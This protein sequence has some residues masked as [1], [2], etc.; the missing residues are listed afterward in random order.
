MFTNNSIKKCALPKPSV[1]LHGVD[2]YQLELEVPAK[3]WT[4]AT[5]TKLVRREYT[6]HRSIRL[7]SNDET[8]SFERLGS[9]DVTPTKTFS[10]VSCVANDEVTANGVA[11]FEREL[12]DAVRY[13]HNLAVAYEREPG[14][15]GN[16]QLQI[17]IRDA[18]ANCANLGV[19]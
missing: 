16:R 18:I 1:K 17:D 6:I 15:Y 10:D 8:L 19:R 11:V 2:I 12:S 5:S 13:E 4:G 14:T 9:S 3:S 7:T